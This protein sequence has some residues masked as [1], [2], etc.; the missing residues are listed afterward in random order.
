MPTDIQLEEDF[1]QG[2]MDKNLFLRLWAFTAPYRW[3]YV[4]NITLA[5]LATVSSL[6]GPKIIQIAVD[7]FLAGIDAHGVMIVSAVFLANLL[8]GWGL[9]IIQTR[10]VT[11]FGER[12]LRD[13]RMEVFRHIQ[14]LSM[15]YF[16]RVQ[17]GRIIARA[18]TDVDALHW[19]ICY[20]GSTLLTS[21]LTLV[22]ALYFMSHYDLRLCMA[23]AVVLPPRSEE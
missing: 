9:T 11:Y 1:A 3:R 16:D 17:A 7:R 20:G 14:R 8:F 19:V 6:L 12:V 18:D 2:K 13:I 4:V 15:S 5:L 21:F 23:T 22:G 10:S